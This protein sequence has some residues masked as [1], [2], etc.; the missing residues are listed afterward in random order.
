M[1]EA[2]EP[3]CEPLRGVDAALLARYDQPGPR[4]TSYPTAVEF[5][6]VDAEAY[7]AL[8]E[9]AD[10]EH[11]APLSVYMHLPFCQERCLFCACHV[12][13]SPDYSRAA[14][15]LDRICQEIDLLAELLPRRRQVTQLHLGG[16][17]PT[18]YT[19]A[20]LSRM[21]TH[22]LERFPVRADAELAVE[23]DPRVTT[24]EHIDMLAEHGFNRLSMGIQDFTPEVQATVNRTQ[25]LA[26]TERLMDR[27]RGRGFHSVNAD[28]IYGMPLQTP[29]TFARTVDQ[30]IGLEADR[31][32]LYSFAF[33]PWMRGHQRMLSEDTLPDRD[34]KF[35]L[36]AVAREQ[37]LEAG[38][39][40]IGMDHFALAGDELAMAR[41]RRELRRNF[42]GY[43][44]VPAP[45]VIGIGISAIGDIGG[46]YIQNQKK[47]SSYEAAL[48]AGRLPIERGLRRTDDDDLRRH[49]IHELMCNFR[50]D[51]RAVERRFEIDFGEYFAT[52]LRGLER[53]VDEQM[54]RVGPDS[55][56]VTP[57]GELFVRNLAMCFDRY[58]REEHQHQDAPMF[59]R[60]V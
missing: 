18:Y 4:Y 8:L 30:V 6:P 24:L 46:S 23:I 15:Y 27:A 57:L 2:S 14:P 49:V 54:V 36:F 16:G 17:T 12:I 44:V 5:A 56:E 29:E 38:Y 37:F 26:Q 20:D 51:V 1:S 21:L 48:D 55:I 39:V 7:G 47:L 33:V 40:P 31:I 35:A 59:S 10:E 22:F 60:T 13:I 50:V 34:T 32:A 41:G 25:T 11:E 42:Q 9:S 53:H 45:D 43:S 28:L 58:W 19:P 52:D 3:I